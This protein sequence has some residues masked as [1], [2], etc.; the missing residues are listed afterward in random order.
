[1]KKVILGAFALL[2]LASCA[3]DRTCECTGTSFIEEPNTDIYSTNMVNGTP[4]KAKEICEGQSQSTTVA[5]IN[6]VLK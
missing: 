3:K 1:M 6:C 2:V 5:E 4:S